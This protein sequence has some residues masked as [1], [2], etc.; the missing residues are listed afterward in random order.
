M[1]EGYVCLH[2]RK[3]VQIGV[4]HQFTKSNVTTSSPHDVLVF[5]RVDLPCGVVSSLTICLIKL[6]GEA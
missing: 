1:H 5:L 3:A 6:S 4:M 2:A